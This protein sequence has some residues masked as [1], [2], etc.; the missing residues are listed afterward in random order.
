MKKA[1]KQA[2]EALALS[3]VPVELKPGKDGSFSYKSLLVGISTKKNE[4][5]KRD[6]VLSLFN[7]PDCLKKK[8]AQELPNEQAPAEAAEITAEEA[9]EPEEPAPESES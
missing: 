2:L 1:S 8:P 7:L 6:L 9:P 5:G 3:L 4:A